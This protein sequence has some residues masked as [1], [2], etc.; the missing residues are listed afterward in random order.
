MEPAWSPNGKKIAAVFP[1]SASGGRL[2]IYTVNANGTGRVRVTTGTATTSPA[3][4]PGGTQIAC[5]RGSQI[6]VVSLGS[7]RVKQVTRP[8]HGLAFVDT[9]AW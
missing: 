9:P 7:G 8:L 2:E 6:G 5:V 1:D 3:W 4:S